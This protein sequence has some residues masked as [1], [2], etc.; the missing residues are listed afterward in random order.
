MISNCGHDE[1]GQYHGGQKGDQT[2]TEFELCAW[3][4]RPWD[5]VLRYN[6]EKAEEVRRLI[7][8]FAIQCAKND[9]IGYDQDYPARYSF[10]D[11]LAKVD[12]PSQIPNKCSTDCSASILAIVDKILRKLGL[13]SVDYTGYTGNMR[14]ILG[15]IGF[16]I[17]YDSKY[18]N[19]ESN[20]IFGDILLNIK[21]HTATYVGDGKEQ[22]GSTPIDFYYGR[23]DIVPYKKGLSVKE[24][25]TCLCVLGFYD[26]K[27]GFDGWYGDG[28]YKAICDFQAKYDLGA[29]GYASKTGVTWRTIDRL[30]DELGMH[31]YIERGMTGKSVYQIQWKLNHIGY[32]DA[33]GNMLDTDGIYGQHTFEAIC[34]LQDEYG[35]GADGIC[36]PNGYTW[37]KIDELMNNPKEDYKNMPLLIRGDRGEYV[38]KLQRLLVSF[39][40]NVGSAGIDG[41]FGVGTEMAV[42][43]FQ[44]VN[45][46]SV[47]GK[48]GQKTWKQLLI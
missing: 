35:Y 4:N 27:L 47:D 25:Q 24:I 7:G 22:G 29:D 32:R 44:S 17:L 1:R 45:N 5:C 9:N 42:K 16:A 38:K 19:G 21:Y 46:L 23:T 12:E 20:L 15:K 43:N 30:I 41:I 48:V 18:L 13:G 37:N 14:E 11:E 31:P 6:G 40:F 26:R 3:Y 39:G 8:N 10:H 28:T 33:N 36:N 2:G 34:K